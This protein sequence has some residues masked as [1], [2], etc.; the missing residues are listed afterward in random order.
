MPMK[1]I[2]GFMMLSAHESGNNKKEHSWQI[3]AIVSMN[4]DGLEHKGGDSI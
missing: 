2:E 4:S 1:E 3:V